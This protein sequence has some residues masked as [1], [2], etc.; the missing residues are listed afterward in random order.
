M[1]LLS[2]TSLQEEVT[3]NKGN[4]FKIARPGLISLIVTTISAAIIG[5]I[6]FCYCIT[7]K[8]KK[9]S[10]KR[11]DQ[12][13]AAICILCYECYSL[14][15]AT[16]SLY[17]V[18]YNGKD[19]FITTFCIINWQNGTWLRFGKAF[20]YMFFFCMFIHRQHSVTN[21]HIQT[22]IV[23]IYTQRDCTIPLLVLHLPFKSGHFM[24]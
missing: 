19:E 13:I 9:I 15:F 18:L 23:R 14:Q 3:N 1:S 21:E 11:S 7:L 5:Y 12:I 22:H 10:I 4:S 24:H 8:R 16:I 2:T 17:G 20:T 6:F